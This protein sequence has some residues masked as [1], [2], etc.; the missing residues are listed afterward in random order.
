MKTGKLILKGTV[1]LLSPGLI[2]SG[3]DE[4]TDMDFIRDSEGKPFIP[5]TSFIG[6]LRHTIKINCETEKLKRFWGSSR[7]DKYYQS[8][9]YCK[10]LTLKDGQYKLSMRDGVAIDNKTGRA[11]ENAKFDYEVIEPGTAFDLEIEIDLIKDHEDFFRRMLATIINTLS[12]G[13]LRIGAK[14]RNGLGRIKLEDYRVYEFDFSKKADILRWLKEDFSRPVNFNMEP[15]PCNES[16]LFRLVADFKIKNSL[17]IRSYS[18]DP[19]APDAV[20]IHSS[21]GPIIPGSSL[22]GAIR[23]RAERIVNTLGIDNYII[24][25]FFGYVEEKKKQMKD[26][27]PNVDD[28][29]KMVTRNKTEARRGRLIVVETLLPDYP[30]EVQTRIKIDRFTG[31]VME[32]ALLET[33][34][35]FSTKEEKIFR[36]EMTLENY[37]PH[38]A[39]LMLLILKD[40][41]T[42]DLAIGGE[43]SIGRGVLQGIK[44]EISYDSKKFII[45]DSIRDLSEEAKKELQKFVDALLSETNK[46]GNQ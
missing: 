16:G 19:S 35:V 31:G 10:D 17:I 33:M 21:Q 42:G 40:L 14:T 25:N 6:V 12:G 41:W 44:A 27:E 37:K 32:G 2:G 24:K 18:G 45:K 13:D 15:L 39:G 3:R 26:E 11:K 46:G 30:E 5:A 22:K 1:K 9:I 43:K 38:E 36:I 34:P 20:H 4:R 28:A 7:D 29:E 8:A 23:A